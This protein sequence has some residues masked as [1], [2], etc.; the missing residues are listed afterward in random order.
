[1]DDVLVEVWSDVVCPWCYIGKRRLRRG[2]RASSPTTPRST[3]RSR[4]STG[5]SSSTRP[6]RRERRCPSPRPTPASSAARSGPRRSSSTSPPRRRRGGS[7]STSTGR[8][9]P[10][11]VTPTACCGTPSERGPPGTQADVK[12]RLLAAYF[13]EGRNVGD[14]DVLAEVAA[15]RRARRRRRRPVPRQRRGRRRGR[16]ARCRSPREAGIT[17]VPT[18]VIDGRWSIPGAQDPAVFVQVLSRLA[19]RR[20]A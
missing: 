2:A 1:M 14:P 13:V 19:E 5:R 9:G 10:T 6:R 8:S 17:A 20:A 16:R 3:R 11:P 12:E 18:Y 4:S 7:S 15:A